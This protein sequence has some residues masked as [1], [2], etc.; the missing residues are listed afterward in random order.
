MKSLVR[1]RKAEEEDMPQVLE[2]IQ[3]LADFENEPDAVEIE[4]TDLIR[5]GFTGPKAFHCFVA[6]QEKGELLGMALVYPRYSTWKGVVLHLEDLLVRQA[7]RGKGVGSQLLDEVV[8]F[9]QEQGVRRVSWEVLDWNHKAID[10][11]K[12]RGARVMEDWHV[13]QL[14]GEALNN[15]FSKR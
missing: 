13:V 6:E 15:Y 1:I 2:M 8:R 10:F 14:D 4:V 12:S 3:E 9:G 11:Y 5:D 7:F